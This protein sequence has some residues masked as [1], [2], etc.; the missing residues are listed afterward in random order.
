MIPKCICTIIQQTRAPVQFDTRHN[1]GRWQQPRVKSGLF[2]QFRQHS[3]PDTHAQQTAERDLTDR[4]GKLAGII[5]KSCSS[6]HWLTTNALSAVYNLSLVSQQW[7]RATTVCFNVLLRISLFFEETMSPPHDFTCSADDNPTILSCLRAELPGNLSWSAVRKLLKG[8]RVSIG[9]VLCMDEARRLGLGENVCVSDHPIPPP[10]TADDVKILHVDTD[11]IIV[12]KPSGMT[13]LRRKDEMGWPQSRR[14]KQPTLDECVPRLIREHA[15]RRNDSKRIRQKLPKL[16]SV[17][18]IDRDTSGLLM[19][20]RNEKAQQHLIEQFAQHKAV[21]R[22]FAVVPGRLRD[23]TICTRLIRDRGDGLRGST[24]D[25][26][27]GQEAITHVST[28]RPLGEFSEI[29]CRLET[30]R[31]NQI[32][33]HLAELGHP[34]CGDVKFRGPFGVPAIT[35]TSRARRLALHAAGLQ[36]QHPT[37]GRNMLFETPWPPDMQRFLNRLRSKAR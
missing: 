11:V 6:W 21:R 33:I 35:D 30:G 28:L 37:E 32:R 18:R 20:A 8:R 23:Q 2:S 10:P 5:A 27:I 3:D 16:F 31:T 26:S 9:G 12:E 34:I 4:S 1:I 13:T 14:L 22:Y 7:G 29:E 24:N 19:F 36:F 15:A 17:H 25:T